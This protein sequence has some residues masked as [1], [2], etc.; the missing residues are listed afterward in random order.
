MQYV[1]T[2]IKFEGVILKKCLTLFTTENNG[3]V[4]GD[5]KL[6]N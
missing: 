4:K 5:K 6:K 1:Y 2:L 3:L